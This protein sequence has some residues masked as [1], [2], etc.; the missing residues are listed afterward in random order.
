MEVLKD[1]KKK[2]AL[3]YVRGGKRERER[4]RERESQNKI[5]Q[6]YDKRRKTANLQ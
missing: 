3:G 5:K 1:K 6:S 4:E 2:E